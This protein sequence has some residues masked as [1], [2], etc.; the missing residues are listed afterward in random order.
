MQA[1]KT[2]ILVVSLAALVGCGSMEKSVKD[3]DLS[4]ICSKTH[5]WTAWSDTR[6]IPH[7]PP[8]D[9]VAELAAAQK[10][11]GALSSRVS[12]LERQLA[13][14]NTRNADLE[15]QLAARDREIVALRSSAGDSAKLASQLASAQGSLNQSQQQLAAA[16]TRNTDLEAQLAAQLAAM[17][18]A[19]GDKDK[20]AAELAKSNQQVTELEGQLADRDKE[21]AGLRGELSAGM[22]K[23][24][25]AQR[26]LIRA[27]RP[28]IEKGDITVDLNNERLLIN[29]ASSYLFGSGQDELKPAGTDALRQVGAVLKD[30]PEYKVAVDGHTDNVPIRGALKKKFPTNKALSES[31]AANAAEALTEGGLG[32]ATTHGYAET[33]PV[34]P[35]TT[36]AGRAKNRRIEVRVTK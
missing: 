35:N 21:L 17:G 19:T 28:Q 23:L 25:E 30:F 9:M 31:R 13:A 34:E 14:A 29:L 5:G 4:P 24:K 16:N 11:N 27:L 18:I 12:D 36:E 6:C 32:T 7:E 33:K 15:A 1:F 8:R 2:A 3:A 26:G 10:Q 20:L 22:A